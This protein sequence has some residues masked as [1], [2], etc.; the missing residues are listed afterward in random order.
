MTMRVLIVDDEPL[1]RERIR[2]LLA[3]EEDVEVVGEC[4]D[5]AE[6]LERILEE[7]PDLVFL[8]V[9][10]P[11][12]TGFDVLEALDEEVLPVVIFVTAYDQYALKAFEAHALDYLMKP[13][14][15]DRFQAALQRARRYVAAPP[16]AREEPTLDER[17]RAVLQQLQPASRYP[18]RIVVRSGH[19]ILFVSTDDVDWV[20]AEG[21]YAR[22]HAGKRT[23]LLRQTMSRLAERLD[24]ERFVRIHRSTIVNIDRI[25]EVQPLFKGTFAVILED[26]TRLQ[27]T[28]GYRDRLQ[29]LI[30]GAS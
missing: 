23:Y 30:E 7:E 10:M 22:L 11:E 4:G 20:D 6:A 29:A 5:G 19:R 26:G 2:D 25:K 9:Q 17:I 27:S 3:E 14:H 13:F 16:P 8:D 12:M 18:Q 24:P 28:R 15:R 1:A 21:N